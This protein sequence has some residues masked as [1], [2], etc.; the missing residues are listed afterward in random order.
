MPYQEF[1][2]KLKKI[3]NYLGFYYTIIRRQ[4]REAAELHSNVLSFLLITI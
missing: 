3:L 1:S 4:H 2:T